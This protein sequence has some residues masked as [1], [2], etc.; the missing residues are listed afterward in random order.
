MTGHVVVIGRC[1][2][3]LYEAGEWSMYPEMM[4]N[5]GKQT[6]VKRCVG[7]GHCYSC[8]VYVEIFQKIASGLGKLACST[9]EKCL[10]Y[11]KYHFLQQL[12]F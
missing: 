9:F 8:H 12:F 6:A 3:I 7:T 2:T 5:R 10:I 11:P 4:G 1:L